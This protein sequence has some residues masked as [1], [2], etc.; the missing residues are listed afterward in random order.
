MA[1]QVLAGVDASLLPDVVEANA[2][3]FVAFLLALLH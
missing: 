2:A 1:E 3:L